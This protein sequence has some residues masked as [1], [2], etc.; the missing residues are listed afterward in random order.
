MHITIFEEKDFIRWCQDGIQDH[1]EAILKRACS[2]LLCSSS[3]RK[4]I[5]GFSNGEDILFNNLDLIEI[6]YEETDVDSKIFN[7]CLAD[8]CL[9]ILYDDFSIQDICLSNNINYSNVEVF[10]N[11]LSNFITDAS[12]IEWKL[13]RGLSI[14][15]VKVEN[16]KFGEPCFFPVSYYLLDLILVLETLT[17]K[18]VKFSFDETNYACVTKENILCY[19]SSER[20]ETEYVI[21]EQLIEIYLSIKGFKEVDKMYFTD[22]KNWSYDD[23][24][25]AL[26]MHILVQNKY[27]SIMISDLYPI[28]KNPM[29]YSLMNFRSSEDYMSAVCK[30]LCSYSKKNKLCSHCTGIDDIFNQEGSC[31]LYKDDSIMDRFFL[32]SE[33]ATPEQQEKVVKELIDSFLLV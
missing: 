23:E 31:P 18:A 33:I 30:Y 2:F 29:L 6:S 32:L 19:F 12:I 20:L 22:M 17:G 21:A 4:D 10:F 26:A 15:C 27:T 25:L 9:T 8:K 24:T 16:P 28:Y 5:K 13:H 11:K 7:T 3:T 1:K 14:P